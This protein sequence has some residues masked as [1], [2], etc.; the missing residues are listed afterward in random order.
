MYMR[1]ENNYIEDQ[2]I[3]D[4]INEGVIAQYVKA[5]G[6]IRGPIASMPDAK[7][8]LL[9]HAPGVF[10]QR[11]GEPPAPE[12][13]PKPKPVYDRN[14]QEEEAQRQNGAWPAAQQQMQWQ[15]PHMQV[16]PR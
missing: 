6:P 13:A 10:K 9:V 15:P 8:K 11:K 1:V 16:W 3:Q 12:N 2:F 5:S 7:V 4:K 14:S